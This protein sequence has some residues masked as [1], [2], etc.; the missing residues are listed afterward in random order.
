VVIQEV[1]HLWI[2]EQD[3][4]DR[5]SQRLTAEALPPRRPSGQ[6]TTGFWERRRPRHILTGKVVCGCCGAAAT[7]YGK[8]YLGCRAAKLGACRNMSTIRRGVLEARVLAALSG[9]LMQPELL[10]EFIAA[11][12]GR[13]RCIT[14][15]PKP[16]AARLPACSRRS[17]RAVI[18]RPWRRFGL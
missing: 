17:P 13:R 12:P 6:A 16:T 2:I 8:D 4:G 14:A 11:W 1:P 18:R 9:Q 3:L 10:D 7:I 5:V 15:S